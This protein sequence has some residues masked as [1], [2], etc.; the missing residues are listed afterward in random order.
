MEDLQKN[1]GLPIALN[2]QG[3]L[4]FLPPLS[5]IEPESRK[6]FDMKD[7]LADRE[8]TFTS[9]D[10]YLMYRGVGFGQDQENF[11]KAALS[12][13][14]TVFRPGLIGREFCK[15]IGHFHAVKPGTNV[16]FP[17][18]YEVISGR[19]LFLIQKLDDA[20]GQITAVYLVDAREGQ[21]AFFP[22]GFG[23][24]TINTQPH[25]LVTANWD[26]TTDSDYTYYKKHHGGAY[27][28]IAGDGGKIETVLNPNY[29]NIPPLIKLR[30][31]DLPGF[32]I[33]AGQPMYNTGQKSLDML[34]F[35]TSPELYLDKL[36]ID[37]C[38]EIV[39]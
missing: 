28:V 15:S 32:G 1:S 26:E 7:H 36:T 29:P 11:K 2:E 5:S 25:A 22:P 27:Y 14:L 9:N 4:E 20:T 31:K 37:Q 21:K 10:V 3:F 39:A 8:A 23:H 38:Y 6:I 12:Y 34:Q 13:D 33:I 17:E 24:I 18:I 30:P 35:I 16:H 19:A